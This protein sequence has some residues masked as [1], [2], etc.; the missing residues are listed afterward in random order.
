MKDEVIL[1]IPAPEDIYH[2][3]DVFN[4]NTRFIGNIPRPNC[5][6]V[7]GVSQEPDFYHKRYRVSQKK[8]GSSIYANII[9][10]YIRILTCLPVE[11]GSSSAAEV[12][13]CVQV[14]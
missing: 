8:M 4:V 11:T 13:V 10:K 2:T 5:Y 7:L 14:T 1:H 6:P 9:K 12:S 3:I